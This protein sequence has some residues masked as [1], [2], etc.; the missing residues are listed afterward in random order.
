MDYQRQVL[1]NAKVLAE[2][3]IK[4]NFRIVSGGTDNHLLLVDLRNKGLTGKEGEHI[5]DEIGITVNKNSIPYDP[6]GP[7]VTSGLRIGTPAITTRGMREEA[8]KTIAHIIHK[9]LSYHQD[10]DQLA[11]A[12]DM[13]QTLTAECPLYGNL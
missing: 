9:A 7:M 2:E 5:L 1:T 12:A 11:A 4:Y 13:V 3:L 10:P 8:I 6:M